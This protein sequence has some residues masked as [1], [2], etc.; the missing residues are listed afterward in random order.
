MKS[1]CRHD[2]SDPAPLP[3]DDDPLPEP[4]TGAEPALGEVVGLSRGLPDVVA[5]W[6]SEPTVELTIVGVPIVPLPMSDVDGPTG[7]TGCTPIVGTVG[8]PMLGSAGVPMVGVVDV[9]MVGSVGVPIVGVSGVPMLGCVEVPMVGIVGVPIVDRVGVPIVGRVGV[10]IVGRVGV[11]IVGLPIV[12]SV[13]APVPNVEDS[14]PMPG[15]TVVCIEGNA[16]II[17]PKP[18]RPAELNTVDCAFAAPGEAASA[19][20]TIHCTALFI[21]PPSLVSRYFLG[22]SI[23]STGWVALGSTV[24][25]MIG[26]HAGGRR[27]RVAGHPG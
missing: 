10:P 2:R 22:S 9:P 12:G 14:A 17:G 23:G 7:G 4:V 1:S 13:A 3:L 25:M 8:V 11:P 19:T 27:S 26:Y 6:P 18:G 21:P 5:N 24:H 15:V 16:D 20:G